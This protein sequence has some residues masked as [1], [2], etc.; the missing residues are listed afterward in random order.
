MSVR[1]RHSIVLGLL[2]VLPGVAVTNC[3]AAAPPATVGMVVIKEVVQQKSRTNPELVKRL[4]QTI[5]Y[6]GL[7]DPK[8]TL[9]QALYLLARRYRLTFIINARAFKGV[10]LDDW[11]EYGVARP[12]QPETKAP[13]GIVVNKL[14]ARIRVPSGAVYVVRPHFIEI[15]TRAAWLRELGLPPDT[16]DNL[17]C[18]DFR[19]VRLRKALVR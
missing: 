16:K 6:Y 10:D 7:D 17:V 9:P 3:R 13:M 12:S 4:A 14:L 19:N 8:A 18:R 15:T 1:E 5:D 2:S 11:D